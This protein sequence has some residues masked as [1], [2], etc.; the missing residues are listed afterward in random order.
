MKAGLSEKSLEAP[1]GAVGLF[2]FEEQGETVLE[3]E[4]IEV[5]HALL[6][7]KG[8]G[9]AGKSEFVKEFEGGML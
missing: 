9:H 4:L 7:L 8:D 2:P 1:L 6:F 5:G 3:G